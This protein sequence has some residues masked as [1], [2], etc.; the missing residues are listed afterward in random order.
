VISGSYPDSCIWHG[1]P[2][3]IAG[4]SLSQ[5]LSVDEIDR[6]LNPESGFR[7]PGGNGNSDMRD[8]ES[9]LSNVDSGGVRVIDT[10]CY[11]IK[12]YIGSYTF[13]RENESLKKKGEGHEEN[14]YS[15][16]RNHH[17]SHLCGHYPGCRETQGNFRSLFS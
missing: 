12:K 16:H 8:L 1:F 15:N 13:A 7:G 5:G 9:A 14:Q 3:H 6:M 2:W 17:R 10:F 4:G 11:R